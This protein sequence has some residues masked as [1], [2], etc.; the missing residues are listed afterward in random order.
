MPDAAP[1]DPRCTACGYSLV[2]IDSAH[3]PECGADVA[4][5]P[6]FRYPSLARS[7]WSQS[8]PRWLLGGVLPVIVSPVRTLGAC[9]SRPRVT[10]QRAMTFALA[11]TVLLIALWPVVK[12]VGLAIGLLMAPGA[13]NSISMVWEYFRREITSPFRW[14]T[15]CG[16]EA[17]SVARW[18]LL[19]GALA[20]LL[21]SRLPREQR[22][23]RLMLFAPWIALLEIGFLVGVLVAF[24]GIVPEP[25]TLFT[26]WPI[27]ARQV[28]TDEVWLTRGV[29]PTLAAVLVFARAVL[30]WRWPA[31]VLLGVV[32]VPAGLLLSAVWTWLFMATGVLG[33][34]YGW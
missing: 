24:P 29:V 6:A 27:H 1:E 3:C 16:W 10:P 11:V 28:L 26:T 23:R 17:W 31:T 9:A 15:Y 19:F 2:G 25:N 33:Y 34:L 7:P 4:S 32:L 22:W 21:P 5:D 20:M 13:G 12:E 18:W 8:H 30:G 14:R